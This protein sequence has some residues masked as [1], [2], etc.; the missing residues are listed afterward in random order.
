MPDN[1]IGNIKLTNEEEIVDGDGVKIHDILLCDGSPFDA[2]EYPVLALKLPR[3][4]IIDET[5]DISVNSDDPRGVYVDTDIIYVCHDKTY[6]SRYDRDFVYI[7]E[8]LSISINERIQDITMYNGDLYLITDISTIH[9]YTTAGV[10]VEDWDFSNLYNNSGGLEYLNGFFYTISKES[11]PGVDHLV[12]LTTDFVYVSDV[13]LGKDEIRN[14]SNWDGDLWTID[15]DPSAEVMR[16]LTV[17]GSFTGDT[18][19]TIPHAVGLS[20]TSDVYTVVVGLSPD[21][22]NIVSDGNSLP[23]MTPPPGSPN[24]YKIIADP[25]EDV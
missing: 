1:W 11:V 17:E 4:L 9:R 19:Q 16:G 8:L 22:L 7:D 5:H 12:K 14:L 3:R 18:R 23:D 21:D 15:R 13:D 20:I 6:V 24:P 25:T 2:T 10:H